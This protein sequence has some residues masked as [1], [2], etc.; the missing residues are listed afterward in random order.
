MRNSNSKKSKDKEP[1]VE[2]DFSQLSMDDIA[3]RVLKT[4]AKPKLKKK[5]DK[6]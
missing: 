6:P 3:K 1:E 5:K 2:V 4:P